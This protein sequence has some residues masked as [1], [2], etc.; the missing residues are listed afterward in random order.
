MKLLAQYPDAVAVSL[1]DLEAEVLT[2]AAREIEFMALLDPDALGAVTLSG[3]DL[4]ADLADCRALS[5]GLAPGN[6]DHR[7]LELWGF[8]RSPAP[9]ALEP[10]D[11]RIADLLQRHTAR[12]PADQRRLAAE[13]LELGSGPLALLLLIDALR[14]S[15]AVLD[16]EEYETCQLLAQRYLA[17][18]RY[19]SALRSC[20][21]RLGQGRSD[22]LRA[23]AAAA[24]LPLTGRCLLYL[25]TVDGRMHVRV[26]RTRLPDLLATAAVARDSIDPLQHRF[27]AHY[28]RG[29]EQLHADI[30]VVLRYLDAGPVHRTLW[31]WGAGR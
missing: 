12:L 31:R 22:Q 2:T 18:S 13:S 28:R 4:R 17:S 23:E 15:A 20:W 7:P 26:P 29:L 6:P 11:G 3:Q 27:P 10:I 1:H 25:D 19:T 21:G 24:V 14:Q 9:Q 5:P 30:E 8:L 16:D